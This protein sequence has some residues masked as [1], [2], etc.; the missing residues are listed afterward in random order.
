MKS[1]GQKVKEARKNAN[2]SQL[3]LAYAIEEIGGSFSQAQISRLEQD[4]HVPLVSSIELI[5]Q[6]LN[7]ELLLVSKKEKSNKG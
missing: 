6:A 4:Q 3:E 5:A 2:M 1:I 7:L